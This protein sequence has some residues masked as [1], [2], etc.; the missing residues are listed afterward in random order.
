LSWGHPDPALLPVRELADATSRA[1]DRYGAD[2]LGYGNPAGPPPLVEFITDR[3]GRTDARAPE[4][5]EVVVTSG[6]SHALDIVAGTFA[7]PGDFVLVDVPTYHLALRILADH[8]VRLIPVESDEH[9]VRVDALCDTVVR[10]RH[11]GKVVRLMYTVP[12]FHNPT[13]RTM[14]TDHRRSVV[15]AASDLDLVVL[16]DDTYRELAY[17]GSA[18]PSLWSMAEPGTVVRIGSFA[19]TVAP[20]LRV[21]YLTADGLTADRLVSSGLLDSGGGI[22]HFAATALAEYASSG[23]FERHIDALRGEYRARRDALAASL[24]R[25]ASGGLS[26]NLPAG[27]YFLWA[28][29]S[30]VVS[31]A[32]LQAAA[33]AYRVGYQPESH[34]GLE[35]TRGSGAIRLSFSMYTAAELEVGARRVALA[36]AS[37]FAQ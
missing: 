17:E 18:P 25:H 1:L 24:R 26:W 22:A 12:T 16:E 30:Q 5:S 8:G 10:L 34:F 19:K 3:L 15:A 27:G 23:S 29:F 4:R 31:D 20:G 9:G 2:M 37:T 14:P 7:R 21:G 11:E 32:T 28:K 33:S 35:A 13:G 36:L 6:A